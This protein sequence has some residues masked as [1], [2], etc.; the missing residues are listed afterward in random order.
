MV[1][2]FGNYTPEKAASLK[3]H[4][5]DR[6]A[7]GQRGMKYERLDQLIVDLLFGVR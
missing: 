3:A 5:F 4:T 7:L 6:F 2:Y 1:P